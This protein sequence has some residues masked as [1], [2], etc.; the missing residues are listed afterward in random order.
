[1]GGGRPGRL[2][3]RAWLRLGGDMEETEF[4]DL[5]WRPRVC[6]LFDVGF[7]CESSD[8]HSTQPSSAFSLLFPGGGSRV[9][10]AIGGTSACFRALFFDL[11]GF[12]K[13]KYFPLSGSMTIQPSSS[14]P[15]PLKYD[16]L[17]DEQGLGA[18]V[19]GD[20]RPSTRARVMRCLV[21]VP[22]KNVGDDLEKMASS[23][24]EGGMLREGKMNSVAGEPWRGSL[25]TNGVAAELRWNCS[26]IGGDALGV[27]GRS[28]S[29][30]EPTLVD[31]L[32]HTRLSSVRSATK[33]FQRCLLF[34][35]SASER[36]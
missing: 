31:G 1:M 35:I 11:V 16:A 14:A 26:N 22:P 25:G 27:V 30:I 23:S 4:R 17:G 5:L 2:V 36:E 21:A 10:K 32:K 15:S 20:R 18:S 12:C 29:D 19:G 13:S 6:D 3:W 33:S 7:V 28:D 24:L 9:G 8:G 34:P